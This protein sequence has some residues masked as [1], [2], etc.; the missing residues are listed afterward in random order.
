MMNIGH[1]TRS[2]S[3]NVLPWS[4]QFFAV[5]SYNAYINSTFKSFIH[6]SYAYHNSRLDGDSVVSVSDT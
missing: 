1:T 3:V 6:L 5:I 2:R 4:V